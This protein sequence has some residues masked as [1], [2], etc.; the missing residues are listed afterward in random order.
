MN[1]QEIQE[2]WESVKLLKIQAIE[3]WN[4][5]TLMTVDRTDLDV[6]GLVQH[7]QV[8]L[9]QIFATS[10]IL[11]AEQ[12]VSAAEGALSPE[13]FRTWSVAR[14]ERANA[15]GRATTDAGANKILQLLG[16]NDVPLA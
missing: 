3:D 2:L 13:D 10:R 7:I 14:T 6:M 9:A 4:P 5:S 16:W 1:L 15:I 12:A 11:K 8:E